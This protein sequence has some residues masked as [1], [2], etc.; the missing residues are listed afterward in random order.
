M[1]IWRIYNYSALAAACH[2]YTKKR[3]LGDALHSNLN[4]RDSM[5]PTSM[6]RLITE[7]T[8]IAVVFALAVLCL[9]LAFF[10]GAGDARLV[11]TLRGPTE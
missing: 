5:L 2:N 11:A 8:R 1:V 7:Q 9:V 10:Y 3:C 6:R 4:K